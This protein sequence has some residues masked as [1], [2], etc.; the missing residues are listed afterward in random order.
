M[1]ESIGEFAFYGCTR[2]STINF[3]NCEYLSEIKSH[4]FD[5]SSLSQIYLPKKL[6]EI[7]AYVFQRCPFST[8]HI[9][10]AIT[11]LRRSCFMYCNL[12]S[13]LII[14]PDSKLFWIED[15]AFLGTSFTEIYIPKD[16]STLDLGAFRSSNVKVINCDPENQ[17]FTFEDGILYNKQRTRFLMKT[18][19]NFT[20]FTLPELIESI[21]GSFFAN[22]PLENITFNS[23][24][25]SI[26]GGAF[27]GSHIGN[28]TIPDIVTSIGNNAFKNCKY[29][30]KVVLG[31]GITKIP[32]GCFENS[33]ITNITFIGNITTIESSA[34][35][36]CVNLKYIK[37]PKSLKTIGGACFPVDAEL[38]FAEDSNYSFDNQR[39]LY[40]SGKTIIYARF[41]KLE[42]YEILETVKFISAGVFKGISVLKSIN[43]SSNSC[44]T[45]IGDDVFAYNINLTNFSFPSSL[46]EIGYNAFRGCT[47]LK[48][49]IFPSNS[50]L[51]KIGDGAFGDCKK[52]EDFSFPNNLKIIGGGAFGSCHSLKNI[53]FPDTLVE[54]QVYGC[55]GSSN[56][57]EVRFG[58]DI[59]KIDV[60]AFYGCGR[61]HTVIFESK[62]AQIYSN[63]FLYCWKLTYVKAT[64]ISHVHYEGFQFCG[65]RSIEFS[66]AI[67]HIGT[68]AFKGSSIIN[69]TFLGNPPISSIEKIAFQYAYH[70]TYINLPSSIQSIGLNAFEWTNISS[71]TI[72]RDTKTISDYAFKSCKNLETFIIS[73]N[74]SLNS[75]GFFVFQG[76]TSIR[77]FICN[78]SDY[79]SVGNRALFD[80]NKTV[81]VC[82]PP[83]SPSKFFY[84][85]STI[86]NISAGAFLACKNLINILI[87]DDSVETI[88]RYAFSDCTSLTHINIP[89]CVQN[90]EDNAFSNCVS[91]TCGIDIENKNETFLEHL[92]TD[93]HLNRDCIRPC[94][95]LTCKK[96]DHYRYH[97]SLFTIQLSEGLSLGLF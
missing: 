78:E 64:N 43:F 73:D 5:E 27:S 58:R 37:L 18:R 67:T 59:K 23:R 36:E 6:T 52:L 66:E 55:S 76:C 62:G 48:T 57:E 24:V 86:R 90:I 75:L 34:F 46:T 93:C 44:L 15:T 87:P 69:I 42:S 77:Q 32:Q 14:E 38:D 17:W 88:Y 7:S 50:S 68:N 47:S 45:K 61:L 26:G 22:L 85:P 74:S 33:S 65:L 39:L 20:S 60:A 21:P 29:L 11:H 89:I 97:L 79:F 95:I 83:A 4:A 41:S 28:I 96:R 49:I 92:Y 13:T 10:N 54:L 56:L 94:S 12:L 9:P 70:L 71:I 51:T 80:K 16:V 82:Y 1:L 84:I 81:L 30:D 91:L 31:S 8:F 3:T 72:P 40:D 2:L 53:S 35:A 63:A 25:K 19:N